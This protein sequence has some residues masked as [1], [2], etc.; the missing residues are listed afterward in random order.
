MQYAQEKSNST[1]A[2]K[3]TK[4]LKKS[5]HQ[6][7]LEQIGRNKKAA[8]KTFITGAMGALFATSE[9]LIWYKKRLEK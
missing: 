6:T 5:L 8:K 9:N 3:Y 4:R 1:L 7:P 2:E